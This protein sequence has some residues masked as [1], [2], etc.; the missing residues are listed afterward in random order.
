MPN[1]RRKIKMVWSSLEHAFDLQDYSISLLLDALRE[2]EDQRRKMNGEHADLIVRSFDGHQRRL[3]A[4]EAFFQRRVETLFADRTREFDEMRSNR[5]K[6][7]ANIRKVNLLV[8]YRIESRLNAVKSTAMSKVNAFMEDGR[9]E[10]RLITAQLQKQ[11]EDVWDQ[12]GSIFS[13]YRKSTQERRRSYDIIERK[14]KSDRQAIIEQDLRI[15]CLLDDIAKFRGKIHLYKKNVE[16]ET[17]DALQESHLFRNIY[18]Q[19]NACPIGTPGRTED[20]RR[21]TVMSRE[22]NRSVKRLKALTRKAE[23][24]LVYIEICR[25]YETRD[26]KILPPI[27]GSADSDSSPDIAATWDSSSPFDVVTQDFE[28]LIR[29]WHRFG[30]AKLVAAELNKER[31]LL[32]RKAVDL[33]ETMKLLLAR[34]FC[35]TSGTRRI[36]E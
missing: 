23:R 24:V 3:K 33:R 27:V 26:E 4:A 11:L 28:T 16:D 17:R 6:N 7:E 13:N 15:A 21:A 36:C 22:Y 31:D 2:T 18:R 10:R 35:S 19:A 1:V 34:T 14:D 30:L 5:N 8:N 29:F 25:K 12:L 20:K 32:A 9:N